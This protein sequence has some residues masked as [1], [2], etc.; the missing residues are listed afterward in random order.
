M[1]EKLTEEDFNQLVLFSNE[2]A[3]LKEIIRELR[4]DL[5]EAITERDELRRRNNRLR[6]TMNKI[7]ADSALELGI[8]IYE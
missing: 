2:N 6:E 1:N 4:Y 5:R 7:Y 3:K 8:D